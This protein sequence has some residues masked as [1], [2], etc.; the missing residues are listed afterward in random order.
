[1]S[2]LSKHDIESVLIRYFVN[3]ERSEDIFMSCEPQYDA[4]P[5]AVDMILRQERIHD[6]DYVVFKHF[7]DANSTI[8]DIGA[9]FGYSATAIW[10]VGSSAAVASFEPIRGYE[11]VLAELGRRVNSGLGLPKYE[12]YNVGLS[13]VEGELLFHC[14]V[15]NGKMNTALTTANPSPNIEA[16]VRNTFVWAAGNVKEITSFKM[17]EFTTKVTTVD[18]W[19]ASQVSNLNISNI[20][21]VKIDTEG[22]E[23]RVLA[24]GSILLS[25]QKPLIL[26]EGGHSIDLAVS[27]AAKHGYVFAGRDGDQLYVSGGPVPG[28]NGFYIHPDKIAFYKQIGL[29]R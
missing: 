22:H 17:H 15:V 5:N 16:Y 23:G 14:S 1:M 11:P 18:R 19:M 4:P 24:G 25:E 27:T 2:G 26:A 20:V 28:V 12:N 6:D 29:V 13:D 10:R 7:T 9:N 21:A 8:L 3:K